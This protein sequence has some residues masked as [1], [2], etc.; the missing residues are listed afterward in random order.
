MVVSAIWEGIYAALPTAVINHCNSK[1]SH[2]FR[3]YLPAWPSVVSYGRTHPSFPRFPPPFPTV[4]V[5]NFTPELRS[6]L[7]LCVTQ[8]FL[9]G[10]LLF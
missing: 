6:R 5:P 2:I 4:T 8:Q 7:N 3:T 10:L 9:L 1:A